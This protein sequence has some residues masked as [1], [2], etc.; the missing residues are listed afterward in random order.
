M[1]APKYR[2]IKEKDFKK[3]NALG[4]SFFSSGLKLKYLANNQE[5]SRFALIVSTKISKK[6]T[7]RNRL[8]RQLREIIRLNQ[9]KVK[10]GYDIIILT[11]GSV[12]NKDYQELEKNVL[13][14]LTEAGLLK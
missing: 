10:S 4:R 14:L 11:R 6:A 9:G 7:Q 13:A 5:L 12:L 3:I 2:L 1:L 8:K